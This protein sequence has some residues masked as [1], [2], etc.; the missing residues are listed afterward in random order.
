MPRVVTALVAIPLLVL[1]VGWGSTALFSLLVL[2]VTVGALFE[3]FLI[4]FPRHPW[5]R[6]LGIG[7]GI[8]IALGMLA[9]GLPGSGLWLAGIIVVAFSVY[10]FLG[11]DLAEQYQHLGWTLLGSLYIGY[12]FPHIVYLH[13]A[14]EGRRWVFFVLLVAMAGDTAGYLVGSAVGKRRLAPRISPG[15]TVEGALGA[16]GASIFFGVFG[17]KFLLPSHP[18]TEMFFLC[19]I[20]NALAQAGDLFESWIKRVFSVK[21]SGALLPGHGGLLDR[22]DSLIFPVVFMTLYLKL[23]RL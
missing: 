11:E 1:I 16:V 6:A 15:K 3:Y 9:P 13:R 22:L 4:A 17:G 7:F 8:L 5:K 23:T 10:H 2:L 12:L 18:W 19:L 14:P 20:V 21:D